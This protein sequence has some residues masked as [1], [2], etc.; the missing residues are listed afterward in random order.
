MA[1]LVPTTETDPKIKAPIQVIYYFLDEVN[2]MMLYLEFAERLLVQEDQRYLKSL[3]SED[4]LDSERYG[5]RRDL[6]ADFTNRFPQYLRQSSL[7]VFFG[8]FEENLNHLCRSLKENR[9]DLKLSP[10]ELADTGIDNS[11]IYLTKVADWSIDAAQNWNHLKNIQK[12]RNNISH[13]SGYL[14]ESNSRKFKTIVEIVENNEH[15]SIET[16]RA[17]KRL[18]LKVGYLEYV[19]RNVESYWR[20]LEKACLRCA[21]ET[22]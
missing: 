18:L 7:L 21:T 1:K 5:F 19:L 17:G 11:R 12:I 9:D 20:T 4:D 2:R 8:M 22:M 16:A 3:E 10:R 15:L 14:P 6:G 13:S